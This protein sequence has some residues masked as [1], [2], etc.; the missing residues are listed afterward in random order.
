MRNT[1]IMCWAI[2]LNEY[3]AEIEYRPGC[4]HVRADFL[5]HVKN[6]SP[7]PGD[8]TILDDDEY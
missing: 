7:A 4:H 2:I 5:S 1:K 3:G 6:N 8:I